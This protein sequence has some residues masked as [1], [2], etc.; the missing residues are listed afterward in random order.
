[1]LFRSG[2]MIGAIGGPVGIAIG[3]GLGA[4]IGGVAGSSG[5]N[6]LN[7]DKLCDQ[8]DVIVKLLVEFAIW[9]N[10]ELLIHRLKVLEKD[11]GNFENFMH[12]NTQIALSATLLTY[13][14]EAYFRATN[15]NKWILHKL[16]QGNE[17]EKVQAGWVAL[18][19][20]VN[21]MSV[22][23]KSRVNEINAQLAIYKRMANP[24]ETES[25]KIGRAHV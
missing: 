12:M 19:E 13:Q 6:S 22:E 21:F 10:D 5:A 20:S 17:M 7:R 9:F 24:E 3:G 14:Y 25:P 2:G 11:L 8:R 16:S 23:L 15:L 4:Y 18:A 1:M